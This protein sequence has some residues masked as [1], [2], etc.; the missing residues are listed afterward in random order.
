[1][2]P[3]SPSAASPENV[4]TASELEVVVTSLVDS[5]DQTVIRD[6]RN[7]W[8]TQSGIPPEFDG[9]LLA[10]SREKI[11]RD[12]NVDEKRFVRGKF[13][14]GVRGRAATEESEAVEP[15]S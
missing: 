1:M 12:L 6:I 4:A 14:E 9:K 3:A 8:K 13:R 5:L 10:Q 2:Q 7:F 15:Q 11:D